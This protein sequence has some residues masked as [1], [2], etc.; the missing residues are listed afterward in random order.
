MDAS[1]VNVHQLS[2]KFFVMEGQLGKISHR[3]A[4]DSC[5]MNYWVKCTERCIL[6]HIMSCDMEAIGVIGDRIDLNK[7]FSCFNGICRA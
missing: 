1:S 7:W 4:T 5:H 6:S 3:L 2:R